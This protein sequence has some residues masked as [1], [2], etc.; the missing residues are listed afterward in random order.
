MKTVLW[1]ALG[2]VLGIV[3]TVTTQYVCNRFQSPVRIYPPSRAIAP[4]SISLDAGKMIRVRSKKSGATALIHF[5]SYGDHGSESTYQWRYRSQAGSETKGT[6]TVKEIDNK[7]L[8][9]VAGGIRLAW[10]WGSTNNCW[11]YYFD[12]DATVQLSPDATFDTEDLK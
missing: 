10:S 1:I 7:G 6:G 11:L 12:Q 3:T 8:P 4:Q 5:T 2:F 9:V